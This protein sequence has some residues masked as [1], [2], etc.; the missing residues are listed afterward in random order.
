MLEPYGEIALRKI[1]TKEL[2]KIVIHILGSANSLVCIQRDWNQAEWSYCRNN[3]SDYCWEKAQRLDSQLNENAMICDLNQG[4]I[5]KMFL[6]K[7]SFEL[8][9]RQKCTNQ[10]NVSKAIAK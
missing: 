9:C 7:G 8:N 3:W 10:L 4:K 5:Y 6:Q 1:L 2:N